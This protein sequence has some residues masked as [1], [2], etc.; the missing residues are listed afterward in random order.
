MNIYLVDASRIFLS[1]RRQHI[2]EQVSNTDIDP[3]YRIEIGHRVHDGKVQL[4]EMGSASGLPSSH[5]NSS[6]NSRNSDLSFLS[7]E[8]TSELT[9]SK[10]YLRGFSKLY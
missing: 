1:S 2:F 10:L 8:V 9:A 5:Y 4:L 7:K 6:Q 3:I